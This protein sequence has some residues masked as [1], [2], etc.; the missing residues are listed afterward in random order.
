M[1]RLVMVKLGR[2]KVH[3]MKTLGILIS[4]GSLLFVLSSLSQLFL[5]VKQ[6]ESALSDNSIAMQLLGIPAKNIS[7]DLIVGYF[8]EPIGWVVL[9]LA[10]LVIGVL[11]Y[12]SGEIIIPIEEEIKEE[13]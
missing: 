4:T 7:P 10:V 11:I 8:L 6:I 9:W 1:K 2:R 5:R 3:L 13:K 12:R